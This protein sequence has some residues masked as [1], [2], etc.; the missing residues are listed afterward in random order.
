MSDTPR[1]DIETLHSRVVYE[2]RWLRLREDG[3]RRRDGSDSIYSVI[4]KPNFAVI[5]ARHDDGRLHL[6]EQFRYP[7]GARFWELPQGTWEG[8][9]TG[10]KAEMLR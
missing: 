3:I 4:E 6:V 1:P 10:A 8:A 9:T 2:N 7:L 5:A